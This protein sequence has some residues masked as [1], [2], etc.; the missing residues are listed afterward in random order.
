MSTFGGHTE[1]SSMD[2]AWT[3]SSKRVKMPGRAVS[4]VARK[5]VLRIFL[6]ERHH[7][8]IPTYLRHDGRR[9]N[10]ETLRIAPDNSGVGDVFFVISRAIDQKMLGQ[11]LQAPDR[12]RH[13]LHR[14]LGD[15]D[16]VDNFMGDAP[17]T[18]ARRMLLHDFE[19]LFPPVG[20]EFF[21]IIHSL[22]PDFFREDD[23]GRDTRPRQWAPAGFVNAGEMGQAGI[24][25]GAFEFVIYH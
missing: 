2:I 22:D 25:E 11:Y 15:V 14:R 7:D 10:G 21:G 24:P 18:D 1:T 5:S 8:A 12:L 4:F 9:G 13:R 17:D 19:Q 16:P 6:V 20:G 3:E 23:G